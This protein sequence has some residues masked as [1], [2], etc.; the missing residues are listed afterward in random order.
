MFV[1]ISCRVSRG[2]QL[3]YVWFHRKRWGLASEG[4]SSSVVPR[5]APS[6]WSHRSLSPDSPS[7]AWGWIPLEMSGERGWLLPFWGGGKGLR[8]PQSYMKWGILFIWETRGRGVTALP[9]NFRN[10]IAFQ[11]VPSFPS[12]PC[13]QKM[14]RHCKAVALHLRAWQCDAQASGKS[15]LRCLKVSSQKQRQWSRALALTG[16]WSQWA[17]AWPCCREAAERPP[18]APVKNEGKDYYSCF[19]LWQE[20]GV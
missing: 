2:M 8:C 17:G 19:S 10:P 6:C 4:I 16:S 13:E 20:R 12:A 1:P 3:E 7:S 14:L 5:R 18:G 11:H 9:L 15:D